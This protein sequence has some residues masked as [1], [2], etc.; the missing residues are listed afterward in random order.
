VVLHDKDK[1]I[2]CGY[3]FYACP[4]GA[5]QFPNGPAAFGARG[6]MDKCTF[7]AGGPEE[8]NSAAEYEKYGSNRLAQGKLPLCAEM[9]STKALIAGDADV[10][11]NI[12]RERVL[13]R[14]GGAEVW[15]WDAAYGGGEQK[16]ERKREGQS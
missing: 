13:R 15:G 9:C 7:C 11:A 3:C 10:V 5:P 4:F 1:C 16:R 14:G 12:F 6:K 2:G 8:T